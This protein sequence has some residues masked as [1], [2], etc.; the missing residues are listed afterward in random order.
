MNL[1]ILLFVVTFY[2]TPFNI[3]P[4]NISHKIK[5][6]K[7]Y[8]NY[9]ENGIGN[10]EF[11]EKSFTIEPENN[12][13]KVHYKSDQIIRIFQYYSD[14][15]HCDELNYYYFKDDKLI[16]IFK[17]HACW[18]FDSDGPYN[19]ENP[20]TLDIMEEFRYYINKDACI[21]YLHKKYEQRNWKKENPTSETTKNTIMECSDSDFNE[22]K[23]EVENLKMIIK[24]TTK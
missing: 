23:K 14:G 9:I 20:S 17:D 18:M 3:F 11:I 5:F 1:Y 15:S 4:Q 22:L 6:I 2:F 24:N 12:V 7:E 10:N 8:Y 16:F 21:K 19:E 13:L